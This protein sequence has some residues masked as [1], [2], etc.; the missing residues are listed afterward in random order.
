MQ[1]QQEYKT[2][3]EICLDKL[4]EIGKSTAKEWSEA[5]NYKTGSCLAKVIRRIKKH[6]PERIIVY[7]TYPKRY[8]YRYESQE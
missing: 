8:E 4:R 5:L 6:Y 2:Y 3:E 7:D 1:Q